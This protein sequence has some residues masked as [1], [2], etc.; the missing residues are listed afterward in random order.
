M[1]KGFL[2]EQPFLVI[3]AVVVIAV[4]LLIGFKFVL[5]SIN[6]GKKLE[7]HDLQEDLQSSL[8]YHNSISPGSFSKQTF[9]TLS[10]INYICFV[11]RNKP[12]NLDNIPDEKY[13]FLIES[14]TESN[15][16]PIPYPYTIQVNSFSLKGFFLDNNPLCVK[17]INSFTITLKRESAGIKISDV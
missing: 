6:L 17:A 12:L 15:V 13:K 5:D 7:L 9:N 3:L 10:E 2:A 14:H 4:I 16:F 1:K 8:D 11:D